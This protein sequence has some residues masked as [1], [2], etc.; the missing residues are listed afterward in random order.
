MTAYVV[1]AALAA[2][3]VPFVAYPLLLWLR[4][5]LRRDPIRGAEIQPDVDLVICAHDEAASIEKKLE[6]ALAL[7]YPRERLVIW[8]ASDG[9]TDGTVAIARRFEPRG[10]RV[11]D[12]PRVG[13]AAAIEAAVGASS[14]EIVAFSDAN[15]MW[16]PGALR[17]LVRP[18]ADAR[19]GGVAGDQRYVA[20]ADAST[21]DAARRDG[22]AGDPDPAHG[23]RTYW[24]FDRR[25]KQWQSE[26]GSAISAT[27]A[28][29]AIRRSLFRVPPADATDDFMIST[30]VIA[31]GRRL[32]FAPD[33]VAFEPPARST[34]GEFRRKVRIV[35]RGLRAV[36]YRRDLLRPSR[37]GLYAVELLLHKVWR[38]LAWIPLCVLFA[39]I[40]S[41][42]ASGGIGRPFA[43]AAT[44]A[45]AGGIAGLL[46]PT[47]RRFRPVGI[48]AYV[49]M[50]NAACAL[51]AYNVLRGRTVSRW[52]TERAT[53]GNGGSPS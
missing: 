8:V 1:S 13:K 39:A 31:R 6:N 32:A 36:S 42:W 19:V 11:L 20:E 52:E 30:E 49:L 29:Y 16:H 45:L 9:S 4:A 46:V 10:V 5:R 51:A 18:F 47:F 27:G 7:D 14:A 41:S 50:V 23:E 44:A 40:P 53:L 24:R 21:L 37:T 34:R 3:A 38:R 43:I 33:A 48:A 15:S 12:L 22:V 35:T 17:A 25:L 28:I 26:S 2:I